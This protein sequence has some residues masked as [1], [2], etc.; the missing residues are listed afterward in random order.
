MRYL[1]NPQDFKKLRI[2]LVKEGL[3]TSPELKAVESAIKSQERALRSANWKFWSPRIALQGQVTNIFAEGGA[4]SEDVDS[5]PFPFP[6]TDET[7]WSVGLNLTFPLFSGGERYS[8]RREALETIAQLKTEKEALA[9]R[10]EGRIR[11]ALH[12][13]GASYAGIQQA[14]NS[15]EA[16]EKNLEIVMDSYAR[17]VISILELIDA[18]NAALVAEEGAANAVYDFLVDFMEVERAVGQFGFVMTAQE[19]EAFLER[20]AAFNED[21]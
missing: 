11:S 14:R 15:A 3:N 17:G 4:G 12:V 21:E 9:E 19:R 2:I 13:A 7:N 16:A 18:Q 5:L 10:I 8:R 1:K 6:E 20:L